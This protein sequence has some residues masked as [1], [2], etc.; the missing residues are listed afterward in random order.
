MLQQIHEIFKRKDVF[1][2][3]VAI[4]AGLAFVDILDT[5]VD[6][7]V[8]PPLVPIVGKPRCILDN[9]GGFDPHKMTR[10]VI[11]TMMIV[12]ILAVW[13]YVYNQG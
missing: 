10:L 13:V 1:E 12:A 3:F 4:F 7:L 11:K 6:E 8:M 9:S 5:V 2:V